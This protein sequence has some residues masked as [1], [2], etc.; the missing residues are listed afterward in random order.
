VG[1]YKRGKIWY[2]DYY[3]QFG[4]RHR[5]AVGPNK[6]QAEQTLS[7]R[8]IEVAEN[9]FLDKK[10]QEKIKF[11]DF[12]DEFIEFHSKPN[13]RSWQRDV[14]LVNHLKAFFGE[15]KLYEITPLD[16]E[17]YKKERIEK[18]KPATVKEK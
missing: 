2:I 10:K 3:D 11:R 13:K 16:I 4:K 5:E 6:R 8:K 9:K 15:K 1:I 14:Q 18:V 17:K 7:K 12:A